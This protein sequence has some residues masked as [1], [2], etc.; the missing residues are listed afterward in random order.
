VLLQHARSRSATIAFIDQHEQLFIAN[1][2]LRSAD[3]AALA[4]VA[5]RAE[6]S[7]SQ[8]QFRNGIAVKE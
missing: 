7:S 4:L 8:Q 2:D 3:N 6:V 1:A 5:G